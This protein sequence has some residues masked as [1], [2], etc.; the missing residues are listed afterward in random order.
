MARSSKPA[1]GRSSTK[2]NAREEARA[3]RK[4]C[5]YCR[6]KITEIDYKQFSNLRVLISE[7]GKIRSRRVT[8][9]CRR[10]QNQAGGAIKR[11]REVA[12]LPIAGA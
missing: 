5:M 3:K 12:L 2:R 8:G 4:G 10:H 7:K 9:L 6:A 1:P 11:A